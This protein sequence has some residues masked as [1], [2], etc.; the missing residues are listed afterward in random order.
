MPIIGFKN[1]EIA[2]TRE[3]DGFEK[4]SLSNCWT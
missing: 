2:G 1:I 3:Y 4:T